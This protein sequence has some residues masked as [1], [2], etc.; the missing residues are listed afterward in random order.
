MIFLSRIK[1]KT[2]VNESNCKDKQV[3]LKDLVKEGEKEASKNNFKKALELFDIA[4][5]LDPTCEFAYGDKA[6]IYDRMGR[7]D[8]SL[9]MNLEALKINSKNPITWHNRGLTMYQKNA[10]IEAIECFDK[11]ILLKE[12]YS[13]AWYNKGRCLEMLGK[14]DDAQ[15]CLTRAKKLDPFLFSKIRFK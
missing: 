6:L 11:C 8:D 15:I 4:I 3:Q 10:F 1:K 5:R 9:R 7:L 14:T 13:K 12:D 2:I